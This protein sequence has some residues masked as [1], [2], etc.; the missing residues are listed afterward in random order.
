M[1]WVDNGAGATISVSISSVHTPG[2]LTGF[3]PVE[4]GPG[5][6]AKSHWQRS[7]KFNE[8]AVILVGGSTVRV[9]DVRGDDFLLIL[10]DSFIR[11][12]DAPVRAT[13]CLESYVFD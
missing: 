2:G 13:V 6:W 9:N 1:V 3:Y 7:A 10:P 11:I 12:R 8:T 4:P 5:T